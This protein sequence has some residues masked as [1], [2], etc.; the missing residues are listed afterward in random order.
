MEREYNSVLLRWRPAIREVSVNRFVQDYSAAFF[1]IEQLVAAGA[2]YA[3]TDNDIFN[4]KD[5]LDRMPEIIRKRVLIVDS[6]EC[7]RM[8]SAIMRPVFEELGMEEENPGCSIRFTRGDRE[9]SEEAAKVYFAMPD[10]LL[11]CSE[12]LQLDFPLDDV[13]TAMDRLLRG[14]RSPQARANVATLAG[15]FTSY[16]ATAVAGLAVRSN[17]PAEASDQVMA[18]FED[19]LY[20][21]MS[22]AGW[23]M[24]IPTRIDRAF[25]TFNRCAR[26]VACSPVFKPVV[27][28]TSKV[29]TAAVHIP[30]PDSDLGS[31][32]AKRG[33]MPPIV[34]L[35]A[36]RQEARDA[37]L[38]ANP[39][40]LI[41][42]ALRRI[43]D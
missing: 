6:G 8:T 33:F 1:M 25:V 30:M 11:A 26:R 40:V 27:H 22:A 39:P 16:R 29:I 35:Q 41:H 37:H 18:L 24:G 32:I 36:L 13:R 2:S 31:L 7:L 21:E 43:H 3:V 42:P 17:M 28:L 14:L 23:L 20:R 9:L 19:E 34:A 5:A 12:K 38:K 10:F 15:V 4:T